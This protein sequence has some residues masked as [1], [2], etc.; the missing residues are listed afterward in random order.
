MALAFSAADNAFD[1]LAK[2]ET[3]TVVYNVTVTDNN[4]ANSTQPV[5]F[6]ITG[7]NDTPV[8]A[9]D[10]TA[11]HALT[12]VLNTTGLTTPDTAS[13][14]LSFTDVDLNDTHSV[15]LGAPAATW[16]A[17]LL[18]GLTPADTTALN[19]ALNSALSYTL[20]DSTHSGAGSVALAFSAADNAFDF[21]AKDE[22]L[23]V[24][25]NVTVTDNNGANSTQPVTF[26]ITGTND[27]PV[28][29]ADTTASHALT[30]VLNT[31]GLTTPDTASAHLSFTDVDLNDTH[32]V[33]LG[34]P[35]ATWSA[36][37]LSGLTPADTTA[38]N[39]ALNSALSYTLTD[40]THSGAGSVALAFS[41]AD[42]AF[43]FLAKDETLTVVYNVTVTD[44][45]G[46]NSTQPVTFIITGT[47]DAPTLTISSNTLHVNEN[48]SIALNI[49]TTDVDTNA[50]LSVT[51]SGVPLNATLTSATNQAGITNNGGGSW[52]IAA[53]ALADLTLNAGE[54]R[55]PATLTVTAH[56]QEGAATADSVAQTIS[57]TVDP[58]ADNP[59]LTGVPSGTLHIAETTGTLN[60]SGISATADGSDPVSIT[61][62]GI[63]SD[64]F[65]TDTNGGATHLTL[66]GGS[67]TFT[68]TQ[69]AA[70]ALNGLTLHAGEE[71]SATITVTA[72]NTE[73]GETTGVSTANFT[74]TVDP[75]AEAPVLGGATSSTMTMGGL[76]TLG[77]TETKFDADD[78]L[79]NVTITGLPHDLADFSGGTYTAS[80][81]TWTGTAAQFTA[82]TFAAGS[83]T[84]TFTLSISAPNTT[85]GEN[86]TAT[87]NYTLRITSAEGP[88]LPILGGATSATVNEGGTV[89]LGVTEAQF[90]GDETL[91]T[92]TI[93]GLPGDLSHFNG[94][95]YTPGTGTWTGTAAQFTAL[96]FVAGSTTGTFTLSISAPNTTPGEAATA[97]EKYTLTVN[98]PPA[99][100]VITGFTTDSGTVGDHI[101]NDTSLTINGTAAANST[102]TLY[103]D[104]VSIG[105]ATVDSSGNWSKADG[106][107]LTN[108][109]TY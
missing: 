20:T 24:V 94:G 99:A 23:T 57:L 52:T 1:F 92:V 86:A 95:T 82:L 85:A 34:A 47:I 8:V 59:V 28:V 31:T 11:S 38:L 63:P 64:A 12:E 13:A 15:T 77:V 76:V 50:S 41:A 109:N 80:S 105:T 78:T 54:E 96:T 90:D 48:N 56:N 42:N 67:I 61:I 104:G 14:H 3:L 101:T 69:I 60:L 21:L 74:L 103:Q 53:A 27:T 89:T 72:N 39:T 17:G 102:V 16:S 91:G 71:T 58:V 2:D 6:I 43:D 29:A 45:N 65:L 84:G 106:N 10:T 18:S 75:V 93:T 4:G 9:A 22:T 70:G 83:T 107:T 40:S 26:I 88:E 44:N 5:T 62:G 87:E 35:A 66:S 7:T 51:I 36:G 32:S 68:A 108:G 19:T 97:T 79:G 100:P 30:E 49:S 55:P 46:A 37:L 25:Y 81:G 73:T 98:A 33:T